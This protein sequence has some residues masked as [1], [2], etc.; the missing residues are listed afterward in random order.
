M[1]NDLPKSNEC[2][3]NTL[4][5]SSKEVYWDLIRKIE[6]PLVSKFKYEQLFPT[7]NLPWK[8][9]Y[10]LPRSVTL[11]S[12]MREFQ[13]RVLS[14]ILYTNKA[15]HKMG[16]VGSAAC[17]F[18]YV[19]DESLEHLFL[20]CPISSTFWLSATKWLKSFFTTIYLLTS[21]NII[22]GLFRKDM[23]LLNNI[24]LLGNEL[25]MKADIL[26]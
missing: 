21:C 3:D 15:L 17:T 2:H 9:I 6:K 23:P 25:F 10:L 11:D 7:H 16:I 14:R 20:H 12:K 4:P 8:D 1:P 5:T 24:I 13:H 26:I 22:F 18:C 19:S